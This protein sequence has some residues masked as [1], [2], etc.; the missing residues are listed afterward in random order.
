MPRS[1]GLC[2]PSPPTG[3]TFE[4]LGSVDDLPHY[5]ADVQAIGFPPEVLGMGAAMLR[6]DGV[7][8]VTPEYDCSVPGALKNALDWLPRLLSTPFVNKPVRIQTGSPSMIG[9][10]RAQYHLRQS[11]VL[12]DAFVLNKPEVMVSQIVG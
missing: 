9:G 8:I 7:I 1:P 6:T 5:D 4:P 11:L 10:V 3:V 2:P 12:L